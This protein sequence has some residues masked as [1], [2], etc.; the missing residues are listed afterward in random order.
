ME[1]I[2]EV[3]L[4]NLAEII[5]KKTG[6]PLTPYKKDE[7]GKFSAQIGNYH[8]D[9]AYGGVALEQMVNIHG[10]VNSVFGCGYVTKRDLYNRMQAFI[11]GLNNN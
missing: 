9:Y 6:N 10:G 1:R 3:D 7:T 4:E 5:N 11:A 8:L 2:R